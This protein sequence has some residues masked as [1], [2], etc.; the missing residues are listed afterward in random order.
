MTVI[1]GDKIQAGYAQKREKNA[2]QKALEINKKHARNNAKMTLL[3]PLEIAR[4]SVSGYEESND[5]ELWRIH[6]YRAWGFP[7]Q[8]TMI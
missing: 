2:A 5:R 3:F 8:T 1:A 7:I 6:E 4:A